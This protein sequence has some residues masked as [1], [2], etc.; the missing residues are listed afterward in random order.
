MNDLYY[1]HGGGV[2]V[3][4]ININ[5]TNMV[6]Y[7]TKQT[8]RHIPLQVFPQNIS[9]SAVTVGASVDSGLSTH[10]L[11]CINRC[12]LGKIFSVIKQICSRVKRCAFYY[13]SVS[14]ALISQNLT[15]PPKC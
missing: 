1:K 10:A 5:R 9:V 8:R 13:V 12:Y 15:K 11:C 2:N 6:N 3:N 4:K 7:V 14:K